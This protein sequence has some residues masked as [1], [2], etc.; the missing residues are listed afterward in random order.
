MDPELLSFWGTASMKSKYAERKEYQAVLI[1][2]W[3]LGC[4]RKRL[5]T[6]FYCPL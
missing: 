5:L 4:S 3:D 2:L 1:E 6:H